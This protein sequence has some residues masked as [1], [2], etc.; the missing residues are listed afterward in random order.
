MIPARMRIDMMNKRLVCAN[1][2]FPAKKAQFTQNDS[3]QRTYCL[4]FG[5]TSA[6]QFIVI[7]EKNTPEK[8]HFLF[9]LNGTLLAPTYVRDP[10]FGT[11]TL[12][13]AE[14]DG[15]RH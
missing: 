14:P 15:L 1:L 6:R 7:M 3:V 11:R 8:R 9:F 5:V 4:R 13:A 10:I 12:T 2:E